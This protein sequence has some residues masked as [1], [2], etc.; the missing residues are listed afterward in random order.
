[1][2]GAGEIRNASTEATISGKWNSASA[3][4][5]LEGCGGGRGRGKRLTASCSKTRKNSQISVQAPSQA[6]SDY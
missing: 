2:N 4:I 6:E 5:W 3:H 1:M